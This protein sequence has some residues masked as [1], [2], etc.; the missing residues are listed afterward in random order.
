MRKARLSLGPCWPLFWAFLYPTQRAGSAGPLDALQEL[1]YGA[2][3]R[4]V[5]AARIS[6]PHGGWLGSFAS[7]PLGSLWEGLSSNER[8]QMREG[9]GLTEIRLPVARSDFSPVRWKESQLT[10]SAMQ[11]QA[12]SEPVLSPASQCA[13]SGSKTLRAAGGVW[14]EPIPACPSLG[15]PGLWYITLNAQSLGGTPTGTH[16]YSSLAP[17]GFGEGPWKS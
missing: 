10:A 11:S 5:A 12:A 3:P 6:G 8:R 4:P 1:A 13:G 2:P 7:S 17:A 16:R 9:A 15:F 14:E